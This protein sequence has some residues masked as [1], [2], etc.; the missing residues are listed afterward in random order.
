MEGIGLAAKVEKMQ[1]FWNRAAVF[2]YGVLLPLACLIMAL[3][4][5]IPY[6]L[7]VFW[8]GFPYI[9]Q[10]GMDHTRQKELRR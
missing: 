10:M 4:D 2:V 9:E 1:R 6:A 7:F 5:S 3:G 8:F